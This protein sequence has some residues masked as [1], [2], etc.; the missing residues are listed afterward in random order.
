MKVAQLGHCECL[1]YLV[2]EGAKVNAKDDTV[3]RRMDIA[4]RRLK[5]NAPQDWTAA[6]YAARYC[7]P[8]CLKV[9]LDAG[10]DINAKIKDVGDHVLSFR[11]T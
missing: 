4:T 2:T 7:N 10:G 9:V 6:M 5:N 11:N 8:E 1:R 3:G